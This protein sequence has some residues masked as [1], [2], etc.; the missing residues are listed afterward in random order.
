MNIYIYIKKKYNRDREIPLLI[1]LSL[2]IH[3]NTR[4]KQLIDTLFE[5][6]MCVSYHRVMS[7]STDLANTVCAKYHANQVVCKQLNNGVFSCCALHNIDHIPSATTAHDLFHGTANSLMQYPTEAEHD[8]RSSHICHQWHSR[9]CKIL[10]QNR[11]K[12][13]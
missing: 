8:K 3:V 11:N 12:Q 1:Y 5:M 13:G 6:G 7:I 4:S 2:F 9:F 10:Y